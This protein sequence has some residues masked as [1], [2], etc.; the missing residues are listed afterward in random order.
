[1]T[2]PSPGVDPR[3]APPNP[4][5]PP[6]HR[7]HPV[8]YLLAIVGPVLV[9][10][11]LVAP[12]AV[13]AALNHW[14]PP[15]AGTDPANGRSRAREGAPGLGD[16]D[17]PAAGNGGYDVGRYEIHIS[18][19]PTTESMRSR[20]T[21]TARATQALVSFYLDLAL[22]TDRVV[23]DGEPAAFDQHG[24]TNLEVTPAQPIANGAPFE[25]TVDYSGKPA[26]VRS[27][28]F[29]GWWA[30]KSEWTA[31]GQ[32]ESAAWW[33]PS[34]DHP[35]DPALMDVSIRVP[36]GLQAISVG[37]LESRDSAQEPD[38]D[39]WH[40]VARQPMAT[41]L[42]FM[43]IGRYE[44]REGVDDGLPYVY[45]VTEALSTA[46]RAKAFATL[47]TS[48]TRVRTLE[49][50]FGPYPFTELGGVVPSHD[51][52]FDGL[53]TQTR[54]IYVAKSLL[55]DDY[56]SELVTHELAHMWFG[57]NVTV[58]QWN[59]IFNNEAYASW[60]AWE[61]AARTGGP[62]AQSS[63]QRSFD[64]WADRP[65]FWRITMINPTRDHLFD[66]VYERGPMTLQALRNVVGDAAF[67]ALSRSWAQDP[68]S[69]SLEEWMTRAQSVTPVDLGPFFQA[70]IYA[71]TAPARTRANGF[72]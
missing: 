59:D 51:L 16:A 13:V 4:N 52:W 43:T 56:A 20:T 26:D 30:A 58:R 68:G 46:D 34:N 9:V 32:P 64:R 28:D 31:A 17:Y 37:R 23:V 50:M 67:L 55:D 5:T 71:P 21:I 24:P 27:G 15:G 10:L 12:L 65:R 62:S 69:R 70:W 6:I 48:R 36:A 38:F 61:Y 14:R 45:A 72:A 35:S 66:A 11:A 33:Y 22:T 25:V 8:A 39:T 41:Y 1:M 40:W 54:P 47:M 53:E 63:F 49:A 44:I 29:P 18:W 57:N 2:A 7:P 3:W 60:A 19:D 42:N